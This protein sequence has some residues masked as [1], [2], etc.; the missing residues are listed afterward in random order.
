LGGAADVLIDPPDEASFKNAAALLADERVPTRVLGRGTNVL[1]RSGGIEGAVLIAGASLGRLERAGNTV[2]AGSGV[3]LARLL[4]FCAGEGLAGLEGLAGIPGSIGGAVVMNAGSHG[5]TVGE[6]LTKVVT[7]EPGKSSRAIDAAELEFGYRSTSLPSRAIVE[8]VSLELERGDPDDIRACQR[9]MLD[10]KWRAQPCGMRS[11]GCIFKNPS[12]AP[13]GLL[14][15][16]AGL[17]GTRVG[18]AVVS[19]QHANFIVNDR[20]ATAD[21]VEELI[22]LVRDR[23]REGSGVELEL[24]IEVIGRRAN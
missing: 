12:E 21:D 14:I 15:D 1:V 8:S 3:P 20:G 2:V 19:D 9:E 4:S 22:Q 13:A 16:Q 11:A 7:F 23:V 10:R 6:R 5:V 17:K 18:G 24:E